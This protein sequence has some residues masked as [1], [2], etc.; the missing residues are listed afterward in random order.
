LFVGAAVGGRAADY[1]GRKRTLVVSLMLFGM[2]SLLT[3]IAPGTGTLLLARLFTG[4]GLGGAMPILIALASEA[5]R[6]ER[7][8]R[9][10]TLVL[11]GLPFGGAL[12]G[13]IALGDR[14]GW[15][16]RSIFVVGGSAPI[17][18]AVTMI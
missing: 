8:L 16:W 17:I 3:S 14:L 2:C 9:A 15:G 1:L 7:R 10:V 13:L 12:A 18:L 6:P 4:L 5:A 11:A